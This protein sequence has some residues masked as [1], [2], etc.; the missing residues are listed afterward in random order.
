VMKGETEKAIDSY[1][2]YELT[3]PLARN[4]DRPRKL[5]KAV[6]GPVY[7]APRVAAGLAADAERFAEVREEVRA[8][9]QRPAWNNP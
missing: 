6:F 1:L 5:L 4:L 2:E 3:A 9:L 7:E 8:M